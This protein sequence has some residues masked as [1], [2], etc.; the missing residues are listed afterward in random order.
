MRE[1]FRA[2][3]TETLGIDDPELQEE[4]IGEYKRTFDDSVM[5]MKNAVAAADFERLRR[6]GHA[7]KGCALNIGHPAGR[8][9]ALGVEMGARNSDLDACRSEIDK[10]AEMAQQLE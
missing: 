9:C 1:F 3:L 2:H 6:L 7:L 10:L 5:Q 4:L 8:E